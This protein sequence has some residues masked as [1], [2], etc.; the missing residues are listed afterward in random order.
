M[1]VDKLIDQATSPGGILAFILGIITAVVYHGIVKPWWCNR[2]GIQ[3][4]YKVSFKVSNLVL[5]VIALSVIWTGVRYTDLASQVAQCQKEFNAALVARSNVSRENDDLS[6]EQREI[7][8]EWMHDIVLPPAPVS[9]WEPNDPRRQTWGIN[10]TIEANNEFKKS[11]D[12][13]TVL[14]NSR[15]ALPDPTCGRE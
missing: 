1:L 8:F 10:R 12:R 15:P 9:D 7:V 11:I 3:L 6:I 13:Q 2:K 4:K 5:A 14:I